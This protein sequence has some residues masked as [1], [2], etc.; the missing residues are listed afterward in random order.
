MVRSK[1]VLIVISNSGETDEIYQIIKALKLIEVKII[2]LTGNPLSRIALLS[3]VVIDVSVPKEACPLGLA[4]TTST[5]ASLAVGDAIAVVLAKLRNFNPKDFRRL[6]PGGHLGERLR[7]PLIQIMREGDEIPWVRSDDSIEK[8]IQEMNEKGLGATLVAESDDSG[9]KVEPRL[10]GIFTDGD[11]RRAFVRWGAA[12]YERTVREV[13]TPR[14]KTIALDRFVSDA[15]EMMERHLIT[16]LP[17]VDYKGTVRGII[18][19]HDLL[20]KG[21]IEFKMTNGADSHL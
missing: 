11:L 21:K 8:A 2:A 10:C 17:I 4:P 3:D 1:D 18:H 16:V 15:L 9:E 20:G 13:M 19:L 14:P 6:H 12:L 5:T 7:V